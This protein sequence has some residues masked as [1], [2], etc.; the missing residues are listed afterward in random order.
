MKKEKIITALILTFFI[1]AA[2]IGVFS[3]FFFTLGGLFVVLGVTFESYWSLLLFFVLL[4]AIGFF[5]ELFFNGFTRFAF[6]FV[7]NKWEAMIVQGLIS[8][9][10]SLICLFIV[11]WIVSTVSLTIQ[12]KLIVALFLMFVELVIDKKW[13]KVEEDTK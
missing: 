9:S 3:L 7:N 10:D 2:V 11:D 8:F 13:R 1:G 5:T 12:A 4:F 6:D